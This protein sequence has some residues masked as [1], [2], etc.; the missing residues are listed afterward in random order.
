MPRFVAP[1]MSAL[2]LAIAALS[3][4]SCAKTG[5]DSAK[6]SQP[7][8]VAVARAAEIRSEV[9]GPQAAGLDLPLQRWYEP[10]PD[11]ICHVVAVRDQVIDWLDL[12]AHEGVDP[13]QL[14]L[15]LG[16]GL[17][18]PGHDVLPRSRRRARAASSATRSP[19]V[20]MRSSAVSLRR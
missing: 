18:I 7:P 17:K 14:R 15:K 6:A 12:V 19:L 9:T 11:W 2:A 4:T 16:L 13:V 8:T 5:K 10:L 20:A 1:V 3:F